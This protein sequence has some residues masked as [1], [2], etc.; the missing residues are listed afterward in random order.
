M[1]KGSLASKV[2]PEQKPVRHLRRELH[3]RERLGKTRRLLRPNRKGE[4]TGSKKYQALT[5]RFSPC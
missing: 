1:C 4:K 5:G 2:I 3:Q